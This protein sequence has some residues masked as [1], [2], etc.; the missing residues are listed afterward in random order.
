MLRGPGLGH[1]ARVM[2]ASLSSML[3]ALAGQDAPTQPIDASAGADD[4]R[5]IVLVSVDQM[6]PAQLERL[7]PLYEG[8][9]ARFAAGEVWRSGAHAHGVTATGPGHA[10]LG[11]GVHPRRHGLVGNDWLAPETRDRLYCVGDPDVQLV[12]PGGPFDSPREQRSPRNLLAPSLGDH[13][14]ALVPEG[15]SVSIAA[16]DRAAIA[17]NGRAGDLVLW[18]DQR[19]RGF[20]SSTAYTQELPDFVS[21]WNAN[22]TSILDEGQGSYTWSSS[23]PPEAARYGTMPDDRPGE[24]DLENGS[25]FPHLAPGVTQEGFPNEI[26]RLAQWLY[27]TPVIDTFTIE[28]AKRAVR[29]LELGTDE[30][31]DTLFVGLSACD[32]AGHLFGPYSEEVTDVLLNVDRQLGTLFELLD[33]RVGEGRWIA[34]LS[35]DHGVLE[36][37]EHRIL[38]GL[39]GDRVSGQDIGGALRELRTALTE[40]YAENVMLGAHGNRLR[41][42]TQ[43]MTD[44]EFDPAEV[45]SFAADFL[46]E[47]VP[48]L[49]VV[50]TLDELLEVADDAPLGQDPIRT[51]VARSTLAGRSPDV[52]WFRPR[53]VLEM[54][55]GTTHGSPYDYDRRVPIAF[56]G[57]GSTAGERWDPAWTVDVL[58]TLLQRAGLAVPDG[59]DGRALD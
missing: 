46:R 30:H 7:S 26:R 54:R 34:A 10:T 37:P 3:L 56:L 48:S 5:L 58:P 55:R 24:A 12:G 15:Q 4:V 20:I 43:A 6:T 2:I 40:R 18:W 42:S 49:S 1:N 22:W 27:F 25:K 39:P 41:L 36:L 52:I 57:P 11:T 47:K 32:T 31:V 13:L 44:G 19:G 16:K 33:D 28:V 45:R 50:F 35:A 38:Q 23:V 21:R 29:D 14:E 17:A 8:G 53:G 59:L 9:L 51:L